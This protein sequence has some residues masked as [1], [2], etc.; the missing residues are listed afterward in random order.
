VPR[1]TDRKVE[2]KPMMTEFMNRSP[3]RDGPTITMSYSRT[4]S[5]Y[6]S[7]AGW[8]PDTPRLPRALW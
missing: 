6:H 2:P 4:I 5:S 8:R 3:K 1:K 7:A